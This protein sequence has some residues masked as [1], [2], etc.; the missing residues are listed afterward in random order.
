M[1]RH[2]G[3]RGAAAVEAALVIPLLLLIVFGI[4]DFGRMLHAQITLTEAAREGAR[5]V[6]LGLPPGPRVATVTSG[7]GGGAVTVE[8]DCATAGATDAVVTVDYSFSFVTPVGAL[9]GIFAGGGFGDDVDMRGRGV[10]PCR[11]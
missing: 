5:A 4:I 9:A 1:T 7:I 3:D 2:R 10:M 8:A 6:S 11:A